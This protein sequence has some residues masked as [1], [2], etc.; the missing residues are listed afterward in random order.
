MRGRPHHFKKTINLKCFFFF[1]AKSPA[2][3]YFID[4][5]IF[6]VSQRSV[7]PK[8]L[9]HYLE[10]FFKPQKPKYVCFENIETK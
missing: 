3:H 6:L 8:D 7:H 5:I 2:S 1:Y 9:K 10:P 4:H